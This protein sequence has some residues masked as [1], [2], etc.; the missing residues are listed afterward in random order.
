M[1]PDWFEDLPATK[2]V[3][4]WTVRIAFMLIGGVIIFYQWRDAQV[5]RVRTIEEVQEV[6]QLD[7]SEIKNEFK[8]L[9]DRTEE[10]LKEQTDKIIEI[11]QDNTRQT[12]KK[13]ELLIKYREMD[14]EMLIDMLSLSRK[15]AEPVAEK[16]EISIGVRKK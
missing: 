13:L 11:I 12:D 8:G 5:N 14:K 9:E 6:Q 16:P 15:S 1:K 4:K 3:L 7:I 10:L 2:T